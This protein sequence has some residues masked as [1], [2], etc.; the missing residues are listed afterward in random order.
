ML[1]CSLFLVQIE[2][3]GAKNLD[4]FK[5]NAD[6]AFVLDEDEAPGKIIVSVPAQN[7]ISVKINDSIST[8]T[9]A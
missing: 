7:S 4:Y 9:K 6:F 3:F 8:N 2:L 1:A 5:I